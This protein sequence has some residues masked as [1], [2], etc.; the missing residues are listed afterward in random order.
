MGV[1]DTKFFRANGETMKLGT[2]KPVILKSPPTLVSFVWQRTGLIPSGLG[3]AI[4]GTWS[5]APP[6]SSMYQKK[7]ESFHEGL[8]IKALMIWD[9]YLAPAWMLITLCFGGVVLRSLPL[10]CS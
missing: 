7:T 10:G 8:A 1:C 4:G 5:K 3:T 9:T 2:R 6:P